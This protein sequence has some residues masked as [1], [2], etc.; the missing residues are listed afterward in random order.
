MWDVKYRPKKFSDVLGQPGIVQVL[1]AR[2]K[3]GTAL[4][5][6]YIFSGGH[7]IGKTTLSRILARALLCHDLQPEGEPC[8]QCDNCRDILSE[9]S[10]AF[11]E[12]DAASSGTIDNVRSMV[13]SLPFAVQGAA[14]R[15]ILFDE[16]HRMS[17][18]SQDVLLK[19]IEDKRLVGIF[20]TTE[21]TK[22]RATIQSRCEE[23]TLRPITREDILA[24]MKRVLEQ[25]GVTY[26][27]DAVNIVIDYSGGHVRDV[28]NRLEMMGQLGEITQESVREYLNL[29]VVS[30]YYE[31]LLSLGDPAVSLRLVDQAVDR[32]GADQVTSGLAEAA[33]SSYRLAHK[34]HSDFVYADRKLAVKVYEVYGDAVVQLARY[35]LR[36]R[37]VTAPGLLCDVVLCAGGVPSAVAES[38]SQVVVNAPQSAPVSV[39]LPE[40][41]TAPT[42]SNPVS[43]PTSAVAAV[44]G[45]E[46]LKPEKVPAPATR[47]L[48]SLDHKAISPDM[49][50][51]SCPE[52]P[53]VIPKGTSDRANDLLTP[54]EWRQAFQKLYLSQNRG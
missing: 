37:K 54:A 36:D 44:S 7:G 21:P 12:L 20:C 31:I 3:N 40:A 30:L 5:T 1:K 9:T 19:P 16:M 11:Q 47:T 41:P 23:F 38:T 10:H 17:R 33:M 29:S 27:E 24:R 26:D 35:F 28:L 50:R 4:D 25:E 46:T 18:D 45:S 6:S 2:L 39:S 13:E 52:E 51:G 15:I 34:M 14:K 8:N 43:E 32:V 42:A 53:L 22:I 49:P 48:T